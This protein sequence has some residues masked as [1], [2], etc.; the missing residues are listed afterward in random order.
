MAPAALVAVSDPDLP[1]PSQ[2]ISLTVSAADAPPLPVA[3]AAE[4]PKV[5][6]QSPT[7]TSPQQPNSE[8]PAITKRNPPEVAHPSKVP[9]PPKPPVKPAPPSQVQPVAPPKTSDAVKT[10]SASQNSV[11]AQSRRAAG[12]GGDTAK[13]NNGSDDTATISKAKY[14]RLVVKWGQQIR[15][16]VAR[17]APKGVGKGRAIVGFTVSANGKVSAIKLLKSSGNARID[18]AALKSVRLAG[19]MPRA[20]RG[21]D[22]SSIPMAVPIFS[23]K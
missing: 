17:H 6:L 2:A 10:K 15:N 11:Q 3:P 18:Q 23:S 20:P 14:K 16:R 12:A 22:V 21:L 8:P 7:P 9:A 19:H 4:P 13:G 1:A 5:S